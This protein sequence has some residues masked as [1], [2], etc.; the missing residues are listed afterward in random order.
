V[1]F[2][3]GEDGEVGDSIGNGGSRIGRGLCHGLGSGSREQRLRYIDYWLFDKHPSTSTAIHPP[4]SP[5]YFL[6]SKKKKTPANS[7]GSRIT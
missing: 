7:Q 1:H 3:D 2:C 5:E 6:E 4:Q